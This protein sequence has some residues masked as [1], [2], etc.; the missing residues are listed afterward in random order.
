MKQEV[1]EM[2]KKFQRIHYKKGFTLTE[3]IIVVAILAVMMAAVAAFSVP[4]RQMVRATSATSDA[5][6]AN[7]IIGE[8]I[9]GRLAYADSLYIH[10]GVN[11][12]STDT[13][14]NASMSRLTNS[15]TGRLHQP[16]AGRAGVLIL[17]YTP[18]AA[19]PEKSGY[20][21]YDFPITSTSSSY[22]TVV[23]NAV[24]T[25]LSDDG[26]VFD[27]AFYGDVQRIIYLPKTEPFRNTTRGEIF[28]N[29]E[30]LS[31][32][33]DPDY[34][35]YQSNG[36]TVDD[37]QSTYIASGT[38]TSIYGEV[39]TTIAGLATTPARGDWQR[40]FQTSTTNQKLGIIKKGDANTSSFVLQNFTSTMLND[41]KYFAMYPAMGT[42][43]TATGSD[44]VIFYHTPKFTA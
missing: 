43:I 5:I 30:I 20:T 18:N 4:V 29:F 28:M 35:Q 40:A 23:Q 1:K 34:I 31:Y 24:G 2:L 38:L 17:R 42:T 19:S 44:I 12:Q 8:Y 37:P 32:Q 11:A 39:D 9:R 25:D 10:Y 6:N 15:T 27:S 13:N 26:A 16:N 3:L 21:L 7:E 41:P 14:I 36:T 33:G 22:T